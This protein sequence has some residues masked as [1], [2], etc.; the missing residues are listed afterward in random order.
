LNKG[1]NMVEQFSSKS[2]L[3]DKIQTERGRFDAILDGLSAEQMTAPELG[4]G[5]SVKDTLAHIKEWEQAMLGW[6][7]ALQSGGTPDRPPFGL[8]DEIVNQINANY[9][10]ANKHK[11]LNQVLDEY[12]ASYKKA[13]QGI[14][15]ASEADLFDVGR[16]EWLESKAFWPVVAANTCW[17]YEEH[18]EEL[19]KWLTG[20]A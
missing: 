1:E 14:Q 12:R 5:W 2:E 8:S 9:F 4:N 11:P 19:E 7:E 10:R 6:L 16:F 15:A 17:H 18:Y 20:S 13:L 3:L